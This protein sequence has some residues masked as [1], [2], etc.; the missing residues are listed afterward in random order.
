MRKL[1]LEP[2]KMSMMAYTCIPSARW[3]DMGG[4]PELMAQPALPSLRSGWVGEGVSG[5]GWRFALGKHG[6]RITVVAY[7]PRKFRRS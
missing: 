6:R 7:F 5:R 2:R 4:Y 1:S 3:A